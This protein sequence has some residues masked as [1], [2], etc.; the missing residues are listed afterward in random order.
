MGNTGRHREPMMIRVCIAATSQSQAQRSAGDCSAQE[1][2]INAIKS[3]DQ[4]NRS[5]LNQ[6]TLVD[7]P[8]QADLIIF[9]ESHKTTT[10]PLDV[11][12]H[13]LHHPI[14]RQHHHKCVIHNGCDLPNPIIPGLYPSIPHKWAR[15]LGCVGSPYLAQ[16]N[17]YLEHP[18]LADT[19]PIRIA[20]FIGGCKDKPLRQHLVKLALSPKWDSI[21]AID[22]SQAFVGSLRANDMQ[23]HQGLKE[24]FAKDMVESKFVL[25]PK[26]S[27]PSSY[28]IFEAMQVARA[29]VI[30]AD[31]FSPPPGPDWSSFSIRI[32]QS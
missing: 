16:L 13:V 22:T 4:S 29:P 20:S 24:A 6:I 10:D 8:D 2:L 3:A 31:A 15:R 12:T 17:P 30:L 18:H 11:S 19:K 25:C 1:F 23:T 26:G 27:G 28:R 5:E 14:Y 21:Q 7:D 9:A 32:R